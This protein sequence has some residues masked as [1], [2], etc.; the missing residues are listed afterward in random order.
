M[1]E[2]LAAFLEKYGPKAKKMAVGAKDLVKEHPV[3]SALA[4]TAAAGFAGGR[5]SKEDADELDIDELLNK[6]H[7][8]HI[9]EELEER[10]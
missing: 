9:E 6:A 5:M 7:K 3:K 8:K 2:K 10:D 1:M 4:G